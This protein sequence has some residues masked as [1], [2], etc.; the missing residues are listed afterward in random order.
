MTGLAVS[1]GLVIMWSSGFIGAELG[2]REASTDT[3]LMWRFLAATAL[4]GAGW[5]IFRRRRLPLRAVGEQ[6]LI[7]L[8]SQGV[9][10]GSI[11]GAIELGVPAG[12]TA[13]IAAV[14]PLLAGTLAGP[15]LGERVSARRW[16]GLGAGLGGVALV[17]SDDLSAGGASPAAFL[18]P[19]AGMAALLAASVLE[20]RSRNPVGLA[21]ALPIHS[22]V[23]AAAL[24]VPALATGAAQPPSGGGF[25]FAVGW[26]VLLST[27][28]GYGCYWLSLRR[29]GVTHTSVL[30]Y[31]TP[32]T[33]ALWG[34]LML[35]HPVSSWSVLGMAVCLGS[36]IAATVPHRAA[37]HRDRVEA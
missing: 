12:T 8:L 19:F 26:V 34:F 7:G 18:L 9:Y 24:T 20:R 27:L 35:G 2:T 29:Y 13:L 36:V 11:V 22:L 10:L 4:L 21:D 37:R 16:I 33:T 23:S 30:I 25:W 15:L 32:P 28:G 5:L 3:L 6:A 1:I 17:V 31:L 14:Q